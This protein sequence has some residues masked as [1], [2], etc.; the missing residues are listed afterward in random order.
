MKNKG[1]I[2][3]DMSNFMV[4]TTFFSLWLAV[5]F[6]EFIENIFAYVLI[7]SL[8]IIH[9]ANDLKLIQHSNSSRSTK[10][11]YVRT[12]TYY[13][14]FVLGSAL[15]FYYVPAIALISFVIFSAYHFGE[16][17]FGVRIKEPTFWG[18]ILFFTYGF[19]ILCLLFYLHAETVTEII[20]TITKI[21]IDERD[22]YYASLG[23]GISMSVL[24]VFLMVRD[25]D[26]RTSFIRETFHI[27]V[28]F[29][30]FSTASLLW[31][32]A[33]YFVIWH[34]I[35][36]LVDQIY[37]LYGDFSKKTVLGYVKASLPYWVISIIGILFLLFV[38]RSNFETSLSFFFSFLAAITF[39]HVL[40]INRIKNT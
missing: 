10:I 2:I 7:L 28:F 30:L 20:H 32:F 34:S 8:G 25:K 22:Y 13:I 35:P 33:I 19:F 31:S 23:S 26:L 21:K 1:Q 15:L 40:V 14:L 29:I 3:I 36:S 12:L 6:E 16:Q 27:V 39:P 38:F 17:H 24:Y 18:N 37:Y 9:G 4:V 5:Q 11:S